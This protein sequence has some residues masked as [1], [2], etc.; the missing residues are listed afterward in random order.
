MTPHVMIDLETLGTKHD[1]V[2]LSIGAA[3]FDPNTLTRVDDTFYVTIDPA[4]CTAFGLKIEASTVLWWM[5]K[6]RRVALDELLESPRVDLPSALDGFTQ[7]FGTQSLPVWGNGATFDNVILRNAFEKIGQPCP[8]EFWHDRCYRTVKA[9]AGGVEIKR[10]GTHHNALEDAIT[11][12]HHL[13]DIVE[14]TGI[15]I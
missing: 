4:T 15:K 5:D 11:Q 12:A 7:W 14:F 10:V 3:K 9:L 2:I 6:D 13:Q 8:W 1:A